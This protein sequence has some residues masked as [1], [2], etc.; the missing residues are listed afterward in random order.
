[1]RRREEMRV[2]EIGADHGLQEPQGLLGA[3][4]LGYVL[5]RM[6]PH[7]REPGSR[8]E[9]DRAHEEVSERRI[10]A[11]RL[12]KGQ[13]CQGTA[14]DRLPEQLDKLVAPGWLHWESGGSVTGWI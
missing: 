5:R 1:M 6:A 3:M 8:P 10:R 13:L 12:G 14:H 2:Q 11:G 7:E 9:Q 4:I